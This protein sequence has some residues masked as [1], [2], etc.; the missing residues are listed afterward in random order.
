MMRIGQRQIVEPFVASGAYKYSEA[1]GTTLNQYVRDCLEAKCAELAKARKTC[2]QQ[3]LA[4]AKA[5]QLKVPKGWKWSREEASR[6][7]PTLP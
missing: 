3:F 7:S 6:D 1:N 5:H 4:F 2:A